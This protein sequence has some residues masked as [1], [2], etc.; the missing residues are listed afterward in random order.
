MNS[1]TIVRQDV[2]LGKHGDEY[3]YMTPEQK[4]YFI[5]PETEH[6]RE[7][8]RDE[9]LKFAKFYLWSFNDWTAM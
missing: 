4:F 8:T 3:L 9:E 2:P 1:E 5:H 7:P 6:Y